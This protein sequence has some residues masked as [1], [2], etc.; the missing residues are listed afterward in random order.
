MEII[1]FDGIDKGLYELVAP[2]VMNPAVLRQNN[3]YP[4]KT[5]FRYV[6]HV[7]VEDGAVMGFMPL[8][9]LPQVS[10]LTTIIYAMMMPVSRTP[11]WRVS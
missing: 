6:W 4:F 9:P 1:R 8:K 5:T 7:A 10:A 3:N 2:V 11:C